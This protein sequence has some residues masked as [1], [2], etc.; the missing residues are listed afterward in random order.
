MIAWKPERITA[1]HHQHLA[2]G[3]AMVDEDGWQRPARFG[4]VEEELQRLQST[5][6]LL[7]I[8]PLGKLSILGEGAEI[9]LGTSFPDLSFPNVGRASRHNPADW[10]GSGPIVLAKLAPDEIMAV[11]GI[12]QGVHLSSALEAADG[13]THVVDLTSAMAGVRV[14]G[15]R[16]RPLLAAITELDTSDS[17]FPNMSCAGLKAAEIRVVILRSDLGQTPSYDLFFARDFGEYMW[18]V[19]M[20]AAEEQGGAPVGLEA[21]ARLGLEG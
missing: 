20:E 10:P 18:E 21:M 8:S 2:R 16:A 15:P 19:L 11:T 4:P 3:A 14:T 13:C 12:D 1:M 9:S 7:D 5:V 6:G 17:S